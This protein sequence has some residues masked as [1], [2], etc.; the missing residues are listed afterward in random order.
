VR[1]TVLVFGL[2]VLVVNYLAD[3]A[4]YLLNPRARAR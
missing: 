1:G 2:V 3:L 4:A